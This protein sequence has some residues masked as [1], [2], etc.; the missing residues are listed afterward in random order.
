MIS[1]QC[2]PGADV[3]AVFFRVALL[4]HLFEAGL[5][6]DWREENEPAALVFRVGAVFPLEQGVQ[7]FDPA[8]FIERLHSEGP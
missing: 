8:K 5:L 2:G 3:D 7:G 1:Q 6:N 4:Q